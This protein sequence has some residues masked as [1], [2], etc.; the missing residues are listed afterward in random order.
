MFAFSDPERL[1]GVLVDAG[2]GGVEITS[3]TLEQ[4]HES[5]PAYWDQLR[6]MAAPI[7]GL[8]DPLPAET[9]A[10]VDAEVH[11]AAEQFRR[12]DRLKIPGTLWLASATRD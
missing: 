6:D 11:A 4:D 12:G 8:Y 1:R 9:R 10:A 3:M 2:F 5:G 7:R